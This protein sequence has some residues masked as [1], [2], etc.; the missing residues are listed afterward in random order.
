M[1]QLLFMSPITNGTSGGLCFNEVF[2]KKGFFFC[3]PPLFFSPRFNDFIALIV[4]PGI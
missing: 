1:K 4:Y 2:K 3:P